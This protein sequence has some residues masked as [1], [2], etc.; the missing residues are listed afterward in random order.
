MLY[1]LARSAACTPFP[2][3]VA[4]NNTTLSVC[5]AADRVLLHKK[6]ITETMW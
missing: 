2:L 1:F 5:G 6:V 4:P 3:P